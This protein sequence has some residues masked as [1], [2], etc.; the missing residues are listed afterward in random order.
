MGYI[1]TFIV[2]V[3]RYVTLTIREKIILISSSYN[4]GS[5]ININ[6]NIIGHWGF[7]EMNRTIRTIITSS[8]INNT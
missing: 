6:N 8:I 4:N 5:H 2:Q 3:F 7:C 1:W